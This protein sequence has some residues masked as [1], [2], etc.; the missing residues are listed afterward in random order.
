MA[1]ASIYEKIDQKGILDA[2]K[3]LDNGV[4][5]A[6]EIESAILDEAKKQ[7]NASAKKNA[8]K[9]ANALIT[10]ATEF[11]QAAKQ[12]SLAKKKIQ[13]DEVFVKAVA[14]MN[15]LPDAQ[16]KAWVLSQLSTDQL[17]GNET[18]I[19]TKQDHPRFLAMFV[20]EPKTAPITLDLL[21]KALKGKKYSLT[22]SDQIA[23]ADGGFFVVGTDFDIDHS[24]STTLS[25]LKE[26]YESDIASILFDGLE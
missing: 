15:A 7:I 25:G 23:T 12:R 20:S 4:Q 19:A 26:Q 13:I 1:N 9:N 14:R 2:A 11:E 6:Q 10:K 22:L 8:D 18:I 5:K 21:N 16:W 3:I 17:A 24:F